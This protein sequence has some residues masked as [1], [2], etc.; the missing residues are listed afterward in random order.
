MEQHHAA[1]PSPDPVR[2]LALEGLFSPMGRDAS[3]SK[4]PRLEEPRASPFASEAAGFVNTY[5]AR[6][7]AGESL[8]VQAR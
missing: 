3:A 7:A 1:G 6:P 2:P 4:R 8:H 5:Q